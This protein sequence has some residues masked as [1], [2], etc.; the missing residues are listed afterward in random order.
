MALTLN[1]DTVNGLEILLA[2]QYFD[3][4]FVSIKQQ[5]CSFSRTE[6][7]NLNHKKHMNGFSVTGGSNI[8][9][10]ASDNGA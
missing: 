6:K 3:D 2:N 1:D 7:Q 4:C 5:D 9:S 8:S 10:I